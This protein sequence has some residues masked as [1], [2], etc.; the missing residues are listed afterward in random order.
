MIT[1]E[2]LIKQHF[3]IRP[4]RGCSKSC[5]VDVASG[6]TKNIEKSERNS[7]QKCIS[8]KVR[9]LKQFNCFFYR[10]QIQKSSTSAAIEHI[11]LQEM[12][13]KKQ[14]R[15]ARQ[16]HADSPAREIKGKVGVTF[17]NKN[18]RNTGQRTSG[19]RHC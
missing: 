2:I 4:I 5:R 15:R 8:Q 9:T 1:R 10:M 14:R 18:R 3:Q 17:D 13:E 12:E 6:Q 16:K 11:A 7:Q 19:H